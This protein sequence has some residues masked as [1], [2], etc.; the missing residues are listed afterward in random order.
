MKLNLI[1]GVL[2][3]PAIKQY[4]ITKNDLP[5]I[6]SATINKVKLSDFDDYL[7]TIEAL[8]VNYLRREEDGKTASEQGSLE[9]L[10]EEADGR[11]AIHLK[12]RLKHIPKL[13]FEERFNMEDPRIFEQVCEGLDLSAS[14]SGEISGASSQILL[15]KLTNYLDV[16][17]VDLVGEISKRSTSFF[18][19]LSNLQT[20]NEQAL[21]CI[22]QIKRLRR[23]IRAISET[24]CE[25][26]LE[27]IRLRRRRE[28]LWVLGQTMQMMADVKKAQP[29]IQILL[30]QGD[31]VGALDLVKES[32]R[33]LRG[34][35]RAERK[36]PELPPTQK[37][38]GPPKKRNSKLTLKGVRTLKN[39]EV[40]F[41]EMNKT[42]GKVLVSDF[43]T[44]LIQEVQF[45]FNNPQESPYPMTTWLKKLLENKEEYFRL[46]GTPSSEFLSIN[47]NNQVNE[48]RENLKEKIQPL[49]LALARID[50]IGVG[51]TAYS[52]ELL[53]HVSVIIK[54]NFPDYLS[55]DA[56]RFPTKNTPKRYRFFY[57]SSRLK[58]YQSAFVVTSWPPSSVP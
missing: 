58:R 2:N 1:S 28:N 16:V 33:L 12:D 17:E 6:P 53:R 18:V 46:L 41:E 11:E 45:S 47:N 3:A 36:A 57:F 50:A 51:L 44:A 25:Q 31:F 32:I 55:D 23:S 13:F 15:E 22:E 40:Q 35:G 56:D 14:L 5:F 34:L 52:D 49:I 19:A 24:Q 7:H 30:G 38:G 29:T 43:V 48:L 9:Q 54:K 10:Q 4:K 26:G 39:L 27:L 20:L 8:Y 21:K 37:E 42:I